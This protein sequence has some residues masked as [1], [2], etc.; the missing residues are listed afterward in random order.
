LAFCPNL[1]LAVSTWWMGLALRNTKKP[2]VD[3]RFLSGSRKWL[4]D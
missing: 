4:G 3:Q 2:L 1:I